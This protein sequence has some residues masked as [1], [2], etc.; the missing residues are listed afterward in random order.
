[1]NSSQTRSNSEEI[2][3]AVLAANLHQY[4]ALRSDLMINYKQ[5]ASIHLIQADK[6]GHRCSS[7]REDPQSI[8]GD[9]QGESMSSSRVRGFTSSVQASFVSGIIIVVV[10]P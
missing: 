10:V 9:E 6:R 3:M 7:K 4:T 2:S 5:F 1:M 8:R